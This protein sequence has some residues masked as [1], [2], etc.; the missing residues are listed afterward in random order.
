VR[1]DV[2]TIFPEMFRSPF[3]A[4]MVRQALDR[5]LASLHVWDLRD[6]CTDRHRTTDDYAYGGGPGMVLK[7]EPIFR[8]VEHVRSAGAR[9]ILLAPQGRQFNQEIAWELARERQL[10]LICGRYEGVDDRVRQALV[11]DELSIGDYVLTGGELPAMVI[12][13]AVV[14][15][16]PGVLKEEVPRDESFASGLLE[17]P[18]FTRPAEYR[19]LKVP[20]VLLSG[21][22]QRIA[23]WRRREALRLTLERRP[24]LLERAELSAEDRRI[25]EELRREQ[26]E[27]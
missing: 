15:L 12:I 25:L 5:G 3:A 7:P 8:A 16:L 10:I 24:D 4:G 17:G 22:H 11:T 23:A 1:I 2:L 14:R 26:R 27:G 21:H 9:V 13:D 20:E 6:F 18:Q 19:G